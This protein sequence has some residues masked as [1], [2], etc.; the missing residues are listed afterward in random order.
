MAQTMT[1]RT[2]TITIPCMILIA[3]GLV[4]A[5]VPA[6]VSFEADKH[7]NPIIT[8]VTEKDFK[9]AAFLEA[10]ER[11]GLEAMGLSRDQAERTSVEIANP[12][13]PRQ[14]IRMLNEQVEVTFYPVMRQNYR[15]KS[16]KSFQLYTFRFPRAL[17]SANVLNDAA[18]ARPPRG[19]TPRFGMLPLPDRIEI[20]DVPGLY[21]DEGKRRTIYWFELGAGYSVTTEADRDELFRVLDDLL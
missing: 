19:V 9:A 7:P 8:W 21:F 5:Q 11:I 20:R 3:T 4:F 17:T 14:R 1:G 15:L 10:A 6:G 13:N 2:L 16:G 18:F 12:S